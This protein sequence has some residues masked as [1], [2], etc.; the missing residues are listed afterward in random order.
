[1]GN[2][3]FNRLTI[4]WALLSFLIMGVIVPVV[5]FAS[6][7]TNNLNNHLQA[8]E[9]E[10]AQLTIANNV[11]QLES[12]VESVSYTAAYICTND[13]VISYLNTMAAAPGSADAVFARENLIKYIRNLSNATMYA[14]NPDISVITRGGSV[15]GFERINK[16]SGVEDFFNNQSFLQ[17]Q[18]VWYDVLNPGVTGDLN[19]TWPIFGKGRIIALLQIK[20]P[21]RFFWDK[22]TNHPLL[23]YRQEIF[24]N[25][26]LICIN[27][28]S[29]NIEPEN[30]A[31][32]EEPIK[33]W[34]MKL[35]VTVPRQILS[36]EVNKQN[37]VFL[38]YFV[39]LILFLFVMINIVSDYMGVP[40]NFLT[41]QM[42]KLQKGDFSISPAPFSFK[43]INLLSENLNE[44]SQRISS[45]MN[46]AS[47]QAALKEKMHYEALMAQINP[48]FL[49]NTLNSIKWI[50]TINGNSL[51]ADMLSKLGGILHYSFGKKGDFIALKEELHFLDD[52]VALMQV[53][54]GNN[55]TYI[56]EVPDELL[57]CQ[58]LRFCLQPIVENAIMH[59]NFSFSKGR[60]AVSAIRK[61]N[62]LILSIEDNG[63][64]M[65]QEAAEQLLSK[66][67]ESV[68]STGIGIWNIQQRI[69]ILFGDPYGLKIRSGP[70]QGC[71]VDITLPYKI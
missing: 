70:N 21:Q 55:I 27:N 63:V 45:L 20:I 8:I 5:I 39:I 57:D 22:M 34:G 71:R 16:I 19:A 36:D 37:I 35:V 7:F 6:I 49:Y 32:F 31:V 58:I 65:S 13:E 50:S 40:I 61:E 54:Y 62:L 59:G 3:I 14:L 41:K 47:E 44:V 1:M 23:Q 15:T 46:T 12:V 43:D 53:R 11:H 18:A 28:S 4:R 56:T 51:A 48:H 42:Q 67:N 68:N 17:N 29:I 25:E 10:S 2:R 64:G 33:S 69:R 38:S 30:A 60:I 24:N 9:Y 26:T 66:K 52:Y